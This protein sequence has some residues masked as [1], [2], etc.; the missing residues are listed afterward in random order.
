M[1]RIRMGAVL[2]LAAGI[3]ITAGG[4]SSSVTEPEAAAPTATG[5]GA[6]LNNGFM[7]SGGRTDMP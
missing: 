3:L 1:S 7:T 6:S 4:C 5:E 2:A